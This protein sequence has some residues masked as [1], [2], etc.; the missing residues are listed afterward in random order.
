MNIK[1]A[2]EIIEDFKK[3]GAKGII[4]EYPKEEIRQVLPE[5]GTIDRESHWYKEMLKYLY[6]NDSDWWQRPLFVGIACSVITGLFAIG[7]GYFFGV[8]KAVNNVPIQSNNRQYGNIYAHQIIFNENG[9]F[10]IY[11]TALEQAT[12]STVKFTAISSDVSIAGEGLSN[13][14]SAPK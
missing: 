3:C 12:G 9:T 13:K 10:K 1:K 4:K 7:V 2:L 11:G 8:Q 14:W 6:K 5:I